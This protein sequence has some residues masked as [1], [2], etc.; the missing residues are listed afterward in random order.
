MWKHDGPYSQLI[1]FEVDYRMLGK[2]AGR[3]GRTLRK[4][5]HEAKRVANDGG[6]RWQ[7]RLGSETWRLRQVLVLVLIKF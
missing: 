6:S 3:W 4:R 2:L 5:R 7:H 1:I